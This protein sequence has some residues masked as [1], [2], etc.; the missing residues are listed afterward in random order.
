M[1]LHFQVIMKDDTIFI[2]HELRRKSIINNAKENIFVKKI[3]EKLT[4]KYL[5]QDEANELKLSKAKIHNC[6]NNTFKLNSNQ[7]IKG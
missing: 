3:F 1:T 5:T 2:L 4:K 6:K 7:A